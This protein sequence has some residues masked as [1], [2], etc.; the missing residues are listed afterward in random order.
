[1]VLK[2][3]KEKV[4]IALK[5]LICFKVEDLEDFLPLVVSADR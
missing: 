1:M 4:S 3:P 2:L 5:N